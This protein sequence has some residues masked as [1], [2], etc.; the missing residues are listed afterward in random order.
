MTTSPRDIWFD[1]KPAG[2][3]LTLVDGE[4]DDSPDLHSFTAARIVVVD[5]DEPTLRVMARMLTRAGY[6]RVTTTDRPENVAALCDRL[7]PDLVVLDL[8]MPQLDGFGVL[9]QL[10][11]RVRGPDR[12]PVIVLTGDDST[13]GRRRALGLG[14]RDFVNKPIDAVELLLRIRNQLEARDMQRQLEENSVMLDLRVAER[15]ERLERAH[16]D[17]LERLALTA[18]CRDDDTS[19]HAQRVGRSAALIAT[20][21]RLDQRTVDLIRVAAPL[22]DIG[23]VAIPDEILH[24]PGPL[25]MEEYEL[26]KTHVTVGGRLLGGGKTPALRLASQIALCH[27]ERW[28]GGGYPFNM[29]GEDIPLVARI[30][31]LADVFDVLTHERPYKGAWPVDKAIAEVEREC[32]AHFDPSVVAA[33]MRLDHPALRFPTGASTIASLA[34]S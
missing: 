6:R 27:H 13:E 20:E 15:T 3:A 14:A 11:R 21:M 22:H 26:M 5:D 30:V 17:M 8:H 31:A 18:E 7:S 33:F 4:I 32:G 10:R 12:L 28:D 24:K 25:T 23:K 19:E 16:L 34:H 29:A 9:Q 1:P 2:K